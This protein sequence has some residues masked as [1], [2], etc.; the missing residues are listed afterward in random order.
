MTRITS[1]ILCIVAFAAGVL[2]PVAMM[3]QQ[4]DAAAQ[5]KPSP[6]QGAALFISSGCP[7]CHGPEGLGTAKAPSLRDIRKRKNDD[8]V[9]HQI[10]EGGKVMP[11]FGEALTDPQIES[12]VEFL[13][14]KK[15]WKGT[16]SPAP[17]QDAT[18]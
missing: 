2:F 12:L 9:R 14:S 15:A 18:K 10:K 6:E 16:L 3:S 13:R 8:E 17:K 4:S 5:V 1:Q 7:Q 11:P